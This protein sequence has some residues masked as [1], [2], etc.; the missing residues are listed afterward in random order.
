MKA[1]IDIENAK[2]KKVITLEVPVIKQ[3]DNDDISFDISGIT[4]EERDLLI[5]AIDLS[6]ELKYTDIE[7]FY[8]ENKPG[9][10][11]FGPDYE[12]TIKENIL[13]GTYTRREWL[14]KQ[15]KGKTKNG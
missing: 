12:F 10:P 3:Y 14:E 4:K 6:K 2:T 7:M 15:K 13:Y 11:H 8:L 9:I 1:S 5:P